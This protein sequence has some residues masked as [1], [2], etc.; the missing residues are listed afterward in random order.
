VL[1]VD[2]DE[3][4]RRTPVR[5]LKEE[6]YEPV[7]RADGESGVQAAQSDE[8][9]AVLCDLNLPDGLGLEFVTRLRERQP[10]LPVVLITGQPSVETA[11]RAV[12]LPVAAYL[13]KPLDIG[14]LRTVLAQSVGRHRHYRGLAADRARLQRWDEELARLQASYREGAKV[15]AGAVAIDYLRLTLTQ[16]IGMLA[17]LERT[18]GA[19]ATEP[20]PGVSLPDLDLLNAVRH[21]ITVL[22]RTRQQF[23]SRELG[24]LRRQLDALLARRRAA[25]D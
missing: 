17:D 18:V 8:F 13:C 19:L 4:V 3:T 16:V 2:D 25:I 24:E 14:A 9:D 23:K 15:D 22:E 21:T 5:W 10:A 6:G 11:A 20:A 12:G 1:L 7:E